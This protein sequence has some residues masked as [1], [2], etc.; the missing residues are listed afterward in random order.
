MEDTRQ[1][2]SSLLLVV[3]ILLV[4]SGFG[5][6]VLTL[7][8]SD[9]TEV[10]TNDH[11]KDAFYV[12]EMGLRV[13]E[14]TLL[15]NDPSAATPLMQHIS[16]AQTAA[17]DPQVPIFPET[18]TDYTLGNL[19]TYLVNATGQELANQPF[20]LPTSTT[21]KT[22]TRAFYSLYVRNNPAD[23]SVSDGTSAGTSAKVDN[24]ETVNLVSVGWVSQGGRIL[25]VKVLEEEYAWIG[26]AAQLI[27]QKGIDESNTNSVQFGGN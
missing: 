18:Q 3:L 11:L 27:G 12:A 10:S 23:T 4:L 1:S 24:D 16:V 6:A 22:N 13:G 5:I 2:G 19:G 8:D 25:S 9:R 21:G 17:V 26:L 14:S 7:T 15:A 20:S